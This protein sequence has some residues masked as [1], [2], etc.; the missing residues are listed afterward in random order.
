MFGLRVSGFLLTAV[1]V[2]TGAVAQPT[3]SVDGRVE[4]A[5]TGSPLRAAHVF[6]SESMIGTT[7]DSTGHFL[8]DGVPIGSERVVVSM[9]GYEPKR[10]N[11]FLQADTTVSMTFAL[12]PNVI[13]AD[14]VVVEGE[15]DEEW[16]DDLRTFKRLFIGTSSLARECT[17]LNPNVLRFD[18][19]W[20]K[21]LE[22]RATAPLHFRNHALGYDLHYSLKEFDQSGT[23][24][25]WDGDPRFEEM[26]PS[27]SSEAARWR[28]NRRSAYRGSLRHF[29]RALISDRVEA[30]GFRMQRIPRPHAFRDPSRADRF[31]ASRDD[32]IV[33]R[34]DSTYRVRFR[35]RLQV[36]YR[37]EPETRGYVRWSRQYRRTRDV[38]TSWIELNDPPVN[39]DRVGEIVEP[40]GATVFGYFAYEQRI[41]GLLPREYRP[42]DALPATAAE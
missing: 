32:V 35:G 23:V 22:A 41:S 24:V 13:Q 16:Y 25:R 11:V 15:R 18:S 27:D 12:V 38:Q 7:T 4:D 20:W 28:E 17:L 29:L 8:L 30:E 5:R 36:T 33:G 21:G 40:Y 1:F 26:T 37:H 2:A 39:V 31:P 14:E 34:T 3:G 6:I 10:Q 9:L 19:S 42:D